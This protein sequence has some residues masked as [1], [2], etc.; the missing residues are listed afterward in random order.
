MSPPIRD[1]SGNG[2]GSIRLG[3]GTEIA[4]V[5][6]G[7]G[8]V[9]FSAIPDSVVIQQHS[10]GGNIQGGDTVGLESS[11][12]PVLAE[13]TNIDGVE[14]Y[15]LFWDIYEGQTD[16]SGTPSYQLNSDG[17][18]DSNGETYFQEWSSVSD[19]TDYVTHIY[20]TDDETR[21]GTIVAQDE[22]GWTSG[23]GAGLF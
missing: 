7:A 18:T 5:R 9:L 11:D 17:T 19:N 1:G 16:K 12:Y 20:A 6:T 10:L 14:D 8:D 13:A 4:E 2:I 3:D 23:G 21:S 22:I 15:L